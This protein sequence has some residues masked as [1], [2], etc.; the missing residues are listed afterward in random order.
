MDVKDMVLLPVCDASAQVHGE[1]TQLQWT[2]EN[3]GK[4]IGTCTEYNFTAFFYGFVID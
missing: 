4:T 3:K 2:T 1:E